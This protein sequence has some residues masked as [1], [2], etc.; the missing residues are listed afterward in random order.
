MKLVAEQNPPIQ[1][2][3]TP[4]NGLGPTVYLVRVISIQDLA[5]PDAG[6]VAILPDDIHRWE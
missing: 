2:K 3:M 4:T 1:W 5:N 6:G